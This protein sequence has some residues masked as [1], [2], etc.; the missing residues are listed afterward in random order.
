MRVVSTEP[1]NTEAMF[2][3]AQVY[4]DLRNHQ[5]AAEMFQKG[6]RLSPR[7]KN[8]LY[9]LG[10]LYY[11]SGRYSDAVNILKKLAEM[12]PKYL[13]SENLLRA[14]EKQLPHA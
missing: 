12:D 13:D 5:K 2:S 11:K 7:N 3:L 4:A 1:R 9:K 8:A 14:V 6:L 10:S